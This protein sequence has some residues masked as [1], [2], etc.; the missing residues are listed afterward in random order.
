MLNLRKTQED[1]FS[2]GK[3]RKFRRNFTKFL[4]LDGTSVYHLVLCM[5]ATS[6]HLP[7]V[8]SQQGF[9]LL[10]SMCVWSLRHEDWNFLTSCSLYSHG[11]LSLNTREDQ[12]STP[13]HHQD[14]YLSYRSGNHNKSSNP[15]GV[16]SRMQ[17]WGCGIMSGALLQCSC[18]VKL[19]VSSQLQE[20]AGC[21]RFSKRTQAVRAKLWE[22]FSL[23]R[24]GSLLCY[25]NGEVQMGIYTFKNVCVQTPC[26][27]PIC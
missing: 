8:F 12:I 18:D 1:I 11:Q 20:M 23:C 15:F 9:L 22:P 7:T 25:I 17:T 13:V 21:Q 19:E 26:G 14:G 24:I 5:L 16:Q 4:W 10:L 2:W 27:H 6:S 3:M